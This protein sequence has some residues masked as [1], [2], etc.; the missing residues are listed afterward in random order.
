MKVGILTFHEIYNPGAYLQAMGTF[1]LLESMGHDPVIINYTAPAHRF[2]LAR[3]LRRNWRVWFRP[4]TV[5]E[6]YGRNQAFHQAQKYFNRTPLLVTHADLESEIFDAV[7]IG[8]DIVW[9]YL[10]PLLGQDPVYF[11]DHINAP[12]KI[13][14]AAS[15]GRVPVDNEP[16]PYVVDGLKKLSSISVRDANTQQMVKKYANRDSVIVC[17]PAFHLD[18]DKHSIAPK[19]DQPYLL[20]YMLPNYAN[21]R[22]VEQIKAYAKKKGLKTIA[23]CYRHK[24][25]DENQICI[26]PQEWLGYI[27]N[28]SAVVTNT[29]H[30]TIFSVKAGVP[31]VS[32]LNDAIR[33]KTITMIDRLGIGDRFLSEE[34]SVAEILECPWDVEAVHQRIEDWR[35]DA[36]S[37]LRDSL[38]K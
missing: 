9:D 34:S 4:R 11:G 18:I 21:A 38:N 20:V 19:E 14:F 30:G 8:A 28:A 3:I 22:I 27:R 36:R 24:W 2:S 6:L 5:F 26:G 1:S 16:P 33:L 13:S 23:V 35:E 15:C 7:V 31:F 12:L 29:F 25:A 17:D 10:R 32:E 37:F